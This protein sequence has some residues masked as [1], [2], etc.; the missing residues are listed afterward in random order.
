MRIASSAVSALL[1]LLAGIVL[2]IS[3]DDDSPGTADAA[4]CDCAAAEPSIPG[5]V[6]RFSN[7]RVIAPGDNGI[8]GAACPQG[9][10]LLSGMCTNQ[11]ASGVDLTLQQFGT[12]DAGQGWSCYFKNNSGTPLTIKATAICLMPGA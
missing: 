12:H 6:M 2:M 8:Q 3:C 7:T 4:T 9:G 1:G 10:L 5:R 11:D